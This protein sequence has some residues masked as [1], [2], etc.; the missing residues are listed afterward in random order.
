MLLPNDIAVTGAAFVPDGFHPR[1]DAVA[2]EYRYVICDSVCPDPFM[3]N[4]AYLLKRRLDNSQIGIMNEAARHLVG[5]HDFSA[6][7]AS[8]SSVS[9]TVR[10]LYKLEAER[11]AEGAVHVTALGDGFLYNMVRILT[12]TILDAAFGKIS[13]RDVPEILAS[14]DRSKAGHTAPAC[15]LYLMEVRYAEKIDFKAE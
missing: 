8:G 6:F 13:P 11:A 1:Y 4:R 12:G 2:K 15:G 14:R 3:R 7:M 5:K 9:D 10:T